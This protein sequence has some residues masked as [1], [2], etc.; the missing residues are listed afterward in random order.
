MFISVYR[1]GK[2]HVGNIIMVNIR[3]ARLEKKKPK[4]EFERLHLLLHYD[5]ILYA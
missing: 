2:Q 1:V 5:N 3:C 4:R